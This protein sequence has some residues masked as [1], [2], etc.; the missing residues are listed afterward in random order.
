[1]SRTALSFSNH[2]CF[3]F[4]TADGGKT[5][6]FGAFSEDMRTRILKKREMGKREG[7]QEA[8]L[9]QEG[10]TGNVPSGKQVAM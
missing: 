8:L 10:S 4:L 3:L 2:P 1:M 6:L 7:G 9:I 5:V